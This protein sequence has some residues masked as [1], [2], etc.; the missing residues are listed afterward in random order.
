ML[1]GRPLPRV[2]PEAAPFWDGCKIGQLLLQTCKQC[3][4]INW[5][6]RTFCYRCASPEFAW[7]AATGRGK[8]ESFSIVYRP[9]DESWASEVPYTLALVLLEEGIRMTTRLIHP[10][11]HLPTIDG[12]VIV[13]FVPIEGGFV[14]PYFEET[15]PNAPSA[16]VS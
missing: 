4:R 1:S 13:R 14:L 3:G 16:G 10:V 6:P 11:G 9:M 8:L 7:I 15:Q 12:S 2:S 5:F